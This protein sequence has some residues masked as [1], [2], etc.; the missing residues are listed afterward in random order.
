MAV[1]IKQLLEKTSIHPIHYAEMTKVLI[2][3]RKGIS[4][5][6]GKRAAEG[7]WLVRKLLEHYGDRIRNHP[8]RK[9]VVKRLDNFMGGN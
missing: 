8:K 9:H 3:Y 5:E 7:K 6:K 4:I 2:E 1:D